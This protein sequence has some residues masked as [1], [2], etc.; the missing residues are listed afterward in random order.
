M[1]EK[2]TDQSTMYNDIIGPIDVWSRDQ[3]N[4]VCP[5]MIWNRKKTSSQKNRFLC[6]NMT[7][8]HTK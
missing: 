3:I 4:D 8:L 2:N 7:C 6:G 1:K 5:R